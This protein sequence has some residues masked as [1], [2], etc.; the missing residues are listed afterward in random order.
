MDS[1]RPYTTLF[2]I[3]SLDGKITTG[4]N[5]SMDTE[6][7]HK[8][9]GIKEGMFQYY[10]LEKR[11]DRVYVNSGKVFEKVGFNEKVWTKDKNDGLSFVVIDNRPHLNL[12]GCEYLAKRCETFFLI[13]NNQNHPAFSVTSKFSNII[14]LVYK[15]KIDFTDAFEQLQQKHK[16]ERMTVQTGGTLNAEFLRLGLIDA[17]SVVVAPCLI[18]GKDTQSLVGGESLHTKEDLKNIKA[19]RLV[20]SE[21]WSNSYIHLKYEVINRT[22]FE[23]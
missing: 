4:D 9:T 1:K 16:I 22:I 3:Q 7:F 17:V 15:R 11:M 18:G 14:P 20:K 19:L 23:I 21:T 5:D 2:L 12:G 8:I 13:T 10:E 6:N